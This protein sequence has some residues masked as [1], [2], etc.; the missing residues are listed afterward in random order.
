MRKKYMWLQTMS[1]QGCVGL[2]KANLVSGIAG[3]PDMFENDVNLGISMGSKGPT[4]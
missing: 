1:S 2:P 4:L 3:Y